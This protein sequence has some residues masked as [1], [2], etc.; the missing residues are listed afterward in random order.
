MPM[1]SRE[2]HEVCAPKLP[3]FMMFKSL[4]LCVVVQY[5]VPMSRL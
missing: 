5:W 1:G 3:L 4:A 2:D